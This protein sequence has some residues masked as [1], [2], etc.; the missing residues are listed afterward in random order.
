MGKGKK[1]RIYPPRDRR[2]VG[3][4][5]YQEARLKERLRERT[6]SEPWV[7][8][9]IAKA[10][11]RD[12]NGQRIH[13][14]YHDAKAYPPGGKQTLMVRCRICGIFTPPHA[15]EQGQCLD[16]AGQDGWGPSPSAV[17]IRK[18]E[19][20]NAEPDYCRLAPEDIA[21]LRREIAEYKRLEQEND[22]R[23]KKS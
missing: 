18:L 3:L 5:H 15:M 22:K 9:Q 23:G 6:C 14:H 16:H 12:A 1:K 7:E 2:R 21:S 4:S 19:R 8:A 20:I 13:Y 17:S 11:D 10:S